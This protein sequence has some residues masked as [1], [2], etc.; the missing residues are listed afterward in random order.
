LD[1][2]GNK[3]RCQVMRIEGHIGL[4]KREF[5]KGQTGDI[6]IISGVPEVT[7]G[8]TLCDPA[9]I[10]ALPP[11]QLDEPTVSIDLTVNSS[12]FAGRSGKHVTMNK[13]R[14]R[15]EREK[16]ANISLKI[17]FSSQDQDVITVAGRGELHLA[18]L[19]EAMRREGYEMSISKPRVII[20][21]E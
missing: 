21:K 13:L 3:T 11:I 6:V 19:I 7:I 1:R 20:K 2:N 12:P 16:R 14:D 4:E 18:V 8:D 9:K 15:L 10:V 17:D 5:E